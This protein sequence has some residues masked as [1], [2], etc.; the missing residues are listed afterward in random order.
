MYLINANKKNIK[1]ASTIHAWLNEWEIWCNIH[2]DTW[3]NKKIIIKD[4]YQLQWNGFVIQTGLCIPGTFTWAH[5]IPQALDL[6]YL[7]GKRKKNSVITR[8]TNL[9][10]CAIWKIWSDWKQIE[11]TYDNPATK[12]RPF[13]LHTSGDPPSPCKWLV[14]KTQCIYFIRCYF[15]C[16]LQCKHLFPLHRPH[17]WN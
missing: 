7:F 13:R 8:R 15:M 6:K 1:E 11:N 17:K 3:K 9:L 16:I 10:W 5:P 2:I 4:T 12:K 14:C